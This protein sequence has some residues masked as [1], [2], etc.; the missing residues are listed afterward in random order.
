MSDLS[1]AK[2]NGESLPLNKRIGS[3]QDKH[4]QLEQALAKEEARPMPDSVTIKSLKLKKLA[5]K[6]E[7]AALAD[8]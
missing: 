7:L 2:E 5:I 1:V 8:S 3:L 4:S 6:D